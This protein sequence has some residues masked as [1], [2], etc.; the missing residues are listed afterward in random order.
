MNGTLIYRKGE[1]ALDTISQ[2]AE[3]PSYFI[4]LISIDTKESLIGRGESVAEAVNAWDVHLKGHLRNAA[5]DDRV[6]VHA[7]ALINRTTQ[8]NEVPSIVKGKV[9]ED[10]CE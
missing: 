5:N 9:K 6:V 10:I 1:H 7:R 4:C 3:K 8:S 2:T